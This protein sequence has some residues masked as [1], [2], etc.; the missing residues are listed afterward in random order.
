MPEEEYISNKNNSD[1]DK[2][3]ILIF[4]RFL[5]FWPFFLISILFF[6]VLSF[7]YLR[8]VDY[9]Y[10]STAKIEIIDKSQD[11]EMALPTAMTIFNRSMINLEN[12]LGVLNSFSLHRKVVES[13][14][15]NIKFYSVGRIKTTE[16]HPDEWFEDYEFSLKIKH[17]TIRTFSSYEIYV[18]NDKLIIDHYDTHD[19]LINSY[20]YDQYSTIGSDNGLPFD[21]DISIVYGDIEYVKQ[22]DLSK[23]VRKWRAGKYILGKFKWGWMPPHPG[24][25]IKK[26]SY[27]EYGVYLLHLATSAD[28]EL[29]L[30]MLEVHQLSNKYLPKTITKM[31]IGGASNVTLSNRWKANRNDKKAWSEHKIKP[32]WFTF[33]LKPL[34]KLP[35]L[36]KI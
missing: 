25:F 7:I 19:E 27:K 17:D 22:D 14:K 30:R 36:L 8:Y 23:V 10:L 24:F 3:L 29:M 21:L 4:Y 20:D 31:R 35:Q 32:Y 1:N 28:Y 18:R 9:D 26:S 5:S 6:L 15:S 16:N 12:E 33:V 13:L 11:S 2:D 34:R